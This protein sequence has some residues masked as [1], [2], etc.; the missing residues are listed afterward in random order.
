MRI[1]SVKEKMQQF[2]ITKLHEL[3]R[4]AKDARAIKSL[5]QELEDGSFSIPGFSVTK[6]TNSPDEMYN[7]TIRNANGNGCDIDIEPPDKKG[8]F[9]YLRVDFL[10]Y[11]QY[12]GYWRFR[13]ESTLVYEWLTNLSAIEA[14]FIDFD[15]VVTKEDKIK[16]I[17]RNSIN[18][19]INAVMANGLYQ[20]YISED[21]HKITLCIKMKKNMQINIPIPYKS[22]QKVL[23]HI[24]G[25]I[26]SYKT[27]IQQSPIKALIVN[28]AL[29]TQW[30]GN[31]NENSN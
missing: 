12:S 20:Y 30:K 13:G 21:E 7:Y 9:R 17:A 19:Y 15:A 31:K 5:W 27:L 23:P 6:Q 18:T 11:G 16:E 24:M 14:K 26:Q 1:K 25:I 3:W 2:L 22:F 8:I 4:N 28:S 29:N 10:C